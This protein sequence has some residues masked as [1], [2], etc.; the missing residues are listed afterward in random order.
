[1]STMTD[2]RVIEEDATNFS[3]RT[4]RDPAE[5]AHFTVP[6]VILYS[7]FIYVRIL[8]PSHTSVT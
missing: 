7:H 8:A 3:L 5:W 1:M 2:A 6:G 4:T